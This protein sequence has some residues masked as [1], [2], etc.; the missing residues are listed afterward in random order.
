MVHIH[1]LSGL[2]ASTFVIST[3][4]NTLKMGFP[5]VAQSSLSLLAR[6]CVFLLWN[7]QPVLCMWLMTSHIHEALG[8]CHG[9]CGWQLG[10]PVIFSVKSGE[11]SFPIIALLIS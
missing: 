10:A 6:L 2:E 9:T 11:T 8:L 1:R 5:H 3:A 7:S 4:Q